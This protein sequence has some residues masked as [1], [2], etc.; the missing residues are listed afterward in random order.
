MEIVVFLGVV[1]VAVVLIMWWSR[2]GASADS[3]PLPMAAGDRPEPGISNE[4]SIGPHRNV[5][6]PWRADQGDGRP[7]R[8]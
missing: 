8:R 2:R 1:L 4:S 6:R 3:L 5:G 7:E